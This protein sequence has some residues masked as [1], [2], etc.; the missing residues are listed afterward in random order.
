VIHLR[1]NSVPS[2]ESPREGLLVTIARTLIEEDRHGLFQSVKCAS[3]IAF[4][5][6]CVLNFEVKG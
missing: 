4:P 5:V 2:F 6:F 3:L 1:Q